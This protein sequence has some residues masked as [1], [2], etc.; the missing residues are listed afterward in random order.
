MS[1]NVNILYGRHNYAQ[2]INPQRVK[3]PVVLVQV[4]IRLG[5]DTQSWRMPSY[6][7]SFQTM[8]NCRVRLTCTGKNLG[9]LVIR[10]QACSI[11]ERSDGLAGQESILQA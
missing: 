1:E 11:E 6:V 2:R 8:S 4:V 5:I 7:I 10:P 3:T 9:G